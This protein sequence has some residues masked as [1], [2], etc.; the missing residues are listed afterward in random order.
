VN[1]SYNFHSLLCRLNAPK[2]LKITTEKTF[3]QAFL[4][5]DK[6]PSLSDR[7]KEILA[8]LAQGKSNK[9]IAFALKITEGTVKQHLFTLFKKIGVTNRTKAVL[10]AEELLRNGDA[11]DGNKADQGV[12]TPRSHEHADQSRKHYQRH[13]TGL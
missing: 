10:R 3:D 7:Q 6:T 9:E 1:F 12:D 5:S 13:D 8:L 4:E 2:P 11:D